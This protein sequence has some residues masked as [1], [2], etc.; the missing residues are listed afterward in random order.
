MINPF[1]QPPFVITDDYLGIT[2]NGFSKN[3]TCINFNGNS[4]T[5][6]V[7]ILLIADR[8]QFSGKEEAL[9]ILLQRFLFEEEE[10]NNFANFS[11]EDTRQF[12]SNFLIPYYGESQLL[13]FRTNEFQQSYKDILDSEKEFAG[14]L[15]GLTHMY[16][17]PWFGIKLNKENV[18]DLENFDPLQQEEILECFYF[19]NEWDDKQ[20][21]ANSR[22]NYI[23]L[24]WVLSW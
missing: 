3:I 11:T 17:E 21:F 24:N 14:K 23:F 6:G 4:E 16:P 15:A 9:I 10:W 12:T 22:H 20:Y 2:L 5:R 7:G 8:K 1:Q 18:T 13:P 19:K